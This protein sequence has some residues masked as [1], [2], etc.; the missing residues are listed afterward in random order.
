[1]ISLSKTVTSV[2]VAASLIA[3]QAVTLASDASAAE[4]RH[5]GHTRHVAPA[6]RHY[7][8]YRGDRYGYHGPRR[9]HTGDAVAGAILG[10]GALIVGSAIADAHR[11]KRYH[12]DD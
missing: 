7:A 4:W 8:P 11:K 1:M 12:D 3:G 2:A 10:I 9:D 5:R 6:P